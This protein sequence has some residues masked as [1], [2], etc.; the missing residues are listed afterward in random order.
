MA[1]EK[2]KCAG[3]LFFCWTG[4]MAVVCVP[5]FIAG[6]S[7]TNSGKPITLVNASA[8]QLESN[9]FSQ[10]NATNL[11]AASDHAEQ[12]GRRQTAEALGTSSGIHHTA[13]ELSVKYTD[14]KVCT[15]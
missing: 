5:S 15:K 6:I 7:C 13:L 1:K 4:L 3:V 9:L 14:V 12:P 8:T 10:S 11:S 2:I